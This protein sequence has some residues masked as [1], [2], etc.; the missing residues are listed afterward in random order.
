VTICQVGTTN[1]QTIDNIFLDTGSTGLRIFQSLVTIQTQPVQGSTGTLAECVG[2]ADNTSDWGPLAYVD[3]KLAGEP[4]VTAPIQLINSQFATPPAACSAGQSTP[5]TSP[6]NASYNGVMGINMLVQDCGQLCVTNPGNG[7][8][9]ACSGTSCVPTATTVQLVNPVSL[10]PTDNNGELLVMPAIGPDGAPT[11]TGSLILGIGTQADNTPSGVTTLPTDRN[12]FITTVFGAFSQTPL[13]SFI[14]SGSSFLSLP[15]SS[16]LPV[17][18]GQAANFF[19]P[20]SLQ[21]LTAVNVGNGG[22]P[23][24]TVTFQ[25]GNADTIAAGSNDAFMDI[26]E[27]AGGTAN[28]QS[29]FDWGFPFFFGRKVY[30]GLEGKESQLGTGPYYA[31]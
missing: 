14:D 9:F 15:A 4:A 17:C 24:S 2:Y 30:F 11:A 18:G 19:C 6:T 8:Y 5:D 20:L 13:Q 25:L 26:G 22:S 3:L 16:S 28:L 10:L 1:C 23:T 27:N 31:Y 7:Q 21:T 29:N 12:G